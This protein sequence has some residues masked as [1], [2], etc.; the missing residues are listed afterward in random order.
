[1]SRARHRGLAI[2]PP[3]V[4]YPGKLSHLQGYPAMTEPIPPPDRRFRPS[5][6]PEPWISALAVAQWLSQEPKTS[7]VAQKQG[8]NPWPPREVGPDLIR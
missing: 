7:G 5:R 1:M 8:E 4:V 2:E 6:P 3:T